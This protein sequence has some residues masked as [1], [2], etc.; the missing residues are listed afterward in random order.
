MCLYFSND[1]GRSGLVVRIESLGRRVAG[2]KPDS[3]EDPPSM[4]HIAPQI[5]GSNRKPSRWC[6]VEAL[7]GGV[8][9][10]VV[11]VSGR[12][13]KLRSPSQNNAR[14]A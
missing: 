2:P 12:G 5:I 10:G 7:R 14:V 1:S 13:S 3:T 9:T 6:G 8:D 11:L 4:G